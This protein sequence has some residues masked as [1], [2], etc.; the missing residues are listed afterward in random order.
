VKRNTLYRADELAALPIAKAELEQERADFEEAV[1][2]A[3]T[4]GGRAL[5]L[6]TSPEC[7]PRRGP[8]SLAKASDYEVNGRP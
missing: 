6:L 8:F 4:K 5:E 3:E 7:D 2:R 1:R